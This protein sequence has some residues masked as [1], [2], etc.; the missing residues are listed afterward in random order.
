[1]TSHL[2]CYFVYRYLAKVV[3]M[4]HL[5]PEVEPNGVSPS[6]DK[7]QMVEA[8]SSESSLKKGGEEGSPGE[9]DHFAQV[10]ACGFFIE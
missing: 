4:T 3:F 9:A 7:V 8:A 2:F 6:D 5:V 1:M 10:G